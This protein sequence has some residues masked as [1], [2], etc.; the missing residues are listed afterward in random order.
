MSNY[1]FIQKRKREQHLFIV[2]GNH[3]KNELLNLLL[4]CFPEMNIKSENIVIYGTNIYDLH[5]RIVKEYG[6]DWADTDVD[7]PY[8]I[9]KMKN[10]EEVWYKDNFINIFLL[11]DYERQDPYFSDCTIDKLQKYFL[12]ETDTGKLYINY[13]MVESYWDS[14]DSLKEPFCQKK[15]M[16]P[17]KNGNAYKLKTEK[18]QIAQ[19]VQFPERLNDVLEKQYGIHDSR[20]RQ[21]CINQILSLKESDFLLEKIEEILKDKVDERLL[22]T[23]KY[24]VRDKVIKIGYSERMVTYIEFMRKELCKIIYRNIR[25]ANLIQ[26]GEYNVPCND[27]KESLYN[28]DFSKILNEQN[29]CSRD[30][31]NG[32]VWVLNTSVLLVPNYAFSL[33]QQKCH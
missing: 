2:E 4:Q 11:F 27:M 18:S 19:A 1:D 15:V 30:E 16:L 25:K 12:D 24:F 6:E 31:K 20:T 22:K 29:N 28:L 26:N 10:L 17:F 5:A 33:I 8:V 23:A 9:S 21:E 7:L 13:P 32:F 14:F 3:E